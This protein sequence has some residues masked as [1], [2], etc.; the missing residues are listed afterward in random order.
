MIELDRE[1]SSI[2]E[3]LVVRNHNIYVSVTLY[4]IYLNLKKE[5]SDG[6]RRIR[7]M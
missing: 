4:S 7:H 3:G 2:P 1:P 5:Y 6:V